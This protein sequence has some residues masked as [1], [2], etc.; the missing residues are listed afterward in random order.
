M[1]N[2]EMQHLGEN[3]SAIRE[4]FEF[5]CRRKAE[6][7]ADS[8]FDF[9]LGNPSVEPP[10]KVAHTI[11]ALSDEKGIHNYTSAPGAAPVR[12]AIAQY[13]Q[14]TFGLAITP[15]YIYLTCGA[16]AALCITFRATACAGDQYVIMAP[17]FPEYY[18]FVRSAGG[19]PVVVPMQ[20][21]CGIN[22]TAMA[23]AINAH[24]KAVIINS[25]NNPSGAVY[26]QEALTALADLLRAKE[27]EYGH[28]IYIIA[29]EPYREIAYDVDV[30][31]IPNIYADT[32]VCYSYS[33]SLS[34]PGERI[35]YVAV[36]PA[37]ADAPALYAA[38]CGAGRALGYVCAPS[39]LQRVIAE[40]QGATSDINVYRTN[41]DLLYNGLTELGFEC[42]RPQGA[43]YLFM[44]AP[45]EDSEAV[46]EQAKQYGLLLVPGDSFG[47]KGW[48]RIA[49]CVDTDMIRRSMSAFASLA[50]YYHVGV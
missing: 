30:P 6:F 17:Y 27:A 25:P 29:D 5:G 4:L 9:S 38:V 42:I 1:I 2:K 41:R 48:L 33:K 10:V 18:V 21:D 46:S 40:M 14:R 20:A 22:L 15:D 32:I 43:F 13:I 35:G 12:A 24:T 7:G 37:A 31:Y 19:E 3:R 45:I 47:A 8:V 28:P 39:M 49:Y 44:R 50:R 26:S 34:L 23:N 16:A 36:N 11:Q